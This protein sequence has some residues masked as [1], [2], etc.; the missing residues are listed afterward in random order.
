M[1]DIPPGRVTGRGWQNHLLI[2]IGPGV[3]QRVTPFHEPGSL[4]EADTFLTRI[5]SMTSA[6]I[7]CVGRR[8]ECS[9]TIYADVCTAARGAQD[10]ELAVRPRA[11]VSPRRRAVE[12]PPERRCTV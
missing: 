1:V 5:L 2:A 4:E 7:A 11:W 12:R 8:A 10:G 3:G 9:P 6:T